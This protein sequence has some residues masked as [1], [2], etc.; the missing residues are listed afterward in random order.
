MIDKAQQFE[1]IE[2]LKQLYNSYLKMQK[3]NKGNYVSQERLELL[4]NAIKKG[5]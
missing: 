5:E 3:D 1:L 4:K 2:E